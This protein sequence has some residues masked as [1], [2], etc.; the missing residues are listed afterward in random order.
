M[1]KAP[2]LQRS[3]W[4]RLCEY[5]SADSLEATYNYFEIAEY[6]DIEAQDDDLLRTVQSVDRIDR[7]ATEYYGDPRLWWVI[8]VRNGWD[9]PMVCL[10]P[11][12]E[13]T[14][15]SPRYVRE[16]VIR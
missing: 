7:L 13:I 9:Q 15:P 3:S 10:R 11:G 5:T 16:V 6:P 14:I 8:A 2:P 12:E 1:A 4:L